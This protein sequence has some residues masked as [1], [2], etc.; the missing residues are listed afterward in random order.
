MSLAPSHTF[1]AV[2]YPWRLYA[3]EDALRQ[4][5]A[6]VRRHKAQRAFVVCGQTVA[7]KTTL[8]ARVQEH[9]GSLY[10]GV[11][12]AMDKDS[13]WPAVE[14]GTA[15]ARAAEADMLI[16]MGGGSVL[17]GTRVMAILLGEN[18]DPYALMTQYPEGQPAYSP[19]LMAPKPP[20]IN[21]VTTPTTAMNRA[22][23]GLKNDTLDHRME[24]TILRPAL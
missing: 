10:A 20:I 6:E 12:D 21:I 18:G 16:A 13:T 5:P 4:L 22:G 11:F 15:A 1:R 24:F 2:S 8:L 23:S 7:H 9:L 17:V 3:G 14:R 19:R